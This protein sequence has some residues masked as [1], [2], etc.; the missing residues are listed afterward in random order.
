MGNR[1]ATLQRQTRE[2]GRLRSGTFD[3]TKGR[4]KGAPQRSKTWIVTS[5]AEHQVEAAAAIWGGRVERWQ[6]QGSG[7]PQFRVITNAIAVE[8]IVPPGDPLGSAY[9]MW[10]KGGIQRNCNGL[11]ESESGSACLCRAK[12]G[13]Q[14]HLFAPKDSACKI[15]S[16]LCVILPQMPDLGVYRVETHSYYATNEIT[17]MVEMIRAAVGPNRL[18]PV[19]LRIEPRTKVSK[20]ETKKFPVVVVELRGAT[21]GELLAATMNNNGGELNYSGRQAIGGGSAALAGAPARAAIEAARPNYRAL[22]A[23]AMTADE[24]MAIWNQALAAGHLD[25]ELKAHLAPIGAALRA[26]ES[27]PDTASTHAAE[28]A[29]ERAEAGGDGSCDGDCEDPDAC[30][31]CAAESPVEQGDGVDTEKLDELWALIVENTPQWSSSQLAAQFASANPG[32][33]SSTAS[34]EQLGEF[35]AWVQGLAAGQAQRES[36][37]VSA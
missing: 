3:P 15:T 29:V 11:V 6:P 37:G 7:D 35:L 27:A 28:S 19:N 23:D 22:A 30:P 16:R 34:E 18:V 20:G 8:A 17:D 32:V 1:I 9:E 26:R 21:A 31:D 14:F 2:L 24:I 36:A 25:D 33:S 4:G 10:S 12:W 5:P 13:E